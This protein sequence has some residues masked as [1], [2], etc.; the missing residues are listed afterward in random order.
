M[1]FS[2]TNQTNS[3]CPAS[4]KHKH[5]RSHIEVLDPEGKG[6]NGFTTNILHRQFK[7][8]LN[9]VDSCQHC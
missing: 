7:F 3:A 1:G 4:N 6:L 8:V 2:L 5:G 9:L